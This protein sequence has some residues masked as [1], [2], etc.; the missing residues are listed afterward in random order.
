MAWRVVINH[1]GPWVVPAVVPVDPP[2][3][4]I[5][6]PD[7]SMPGYAQQRYMSEVDANR[8]A[9]LFRARGFSA[10]TERVDD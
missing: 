4:W 6:A 9:L 5:E 10:A 3:G 7:G 8:V 2:G 1:D